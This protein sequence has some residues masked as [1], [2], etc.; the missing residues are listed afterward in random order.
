MAPLGI[1][2]ERVLLTT[3]TIPAK[4][5]YS[6]LRLGQL[7][8]LSGSVELKNMIFLESLL[9]F[10]VSSGAMLGGRPGVRVS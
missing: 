2:E 6:F 4:K 3:V 10:R 9:S 5:T 8:G 1:D 7:Y